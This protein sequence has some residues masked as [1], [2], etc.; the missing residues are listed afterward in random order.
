[1][2]PLQVLSLQSQA[3]KINLLYFFFLTP[4]KNDFE[5]KIYRQKIK[6]NEKTN[7]IYERMKEMWERERERNRRKNI[8]WFTF[9]KVMFLNKNWFF[10]EQKPQQKNE[11]SLFHIEFTIFFYIF[12]IIS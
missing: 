2:H 10:F 12:I 9:S 7:K 11:N 3:H 6:G 5:E 4:Q 8:T 1:M